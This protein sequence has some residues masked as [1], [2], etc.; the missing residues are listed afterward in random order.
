MTPGAL[1]LYITSFFGLY[2][3]IL[4]LLSFFQNTNNLSSPRPRTLPSVTIAVPAFNEESTLA[5]TLKSLL[6]LDYPAEKVQVIVVDDGSTDRTHTIAL[7]F[8]HAGCADSPD[9]T[10]IH[11]EKNSGKAD[12]LNRALYLARGELF[13]ALDADSFVDPAALRKM[14]GYFADPSVMAVTPSLKIYHPTTFWQKIQYVEYLLGVYLRK[15][16]SYFGSIHVT[17]GPFTIFR[18]S[19]FETYGPYDSNNL[20]ED[21]EVALRIQHHNYRIQNTI[22]A[23]VH[24][25]GPQSWSALIRQRKRWYIGFINNV[26]AYKHLFSRKHGNLGLFILPGA[27]VSIGLAIVLLGY[28]GY[29]M[30]DRLIHLVQNLVAINFDLL[31]WLQFHFDPFFI[32]IDSLTVLALIALCSGLL[33]LYLAKKYSRESGS[34]SVPYLFYLLVYWVVFAVWWCIALHAKVARKKVTWG[35]YQA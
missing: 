32:S 16:F 21:I 25:V 10:V 14:V 29:K 35:K 12:S 31:P 20:T 30:L 8:A 13:G 3:S 18:K 7:K 28:L 27:F 22:D 6:E 15:V 9:I 23:S 34:V 1:L 4:F 33:V 17:P 24:T 19:F 11:N 2:T 26:I 5:A